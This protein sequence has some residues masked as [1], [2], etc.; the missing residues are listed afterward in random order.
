MHGELVFVFSVQDEQ[1][2]FPFFDER[3]ILGDPPPH[4]HD[5][6][7]PQGK[8]LIFDDASALGNEVMRL[9]QELRGNCLPGDFGF[10]GRNFCNRVHI[11]LVDRH[12]FDMGQA[13]CPPRRRERQRRIDQ[14]AVARQVIG[15][16]HDVVRVLDAVRQRTVGGRVRQDEDGIGSRLRHD[17]EV[18]AQAVWPVPGVGMKMPIGD[19]EVGSRRFDSIE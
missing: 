10:D 13:A 17:I 6:L 14:P 8:T 3:L 5:F 2:D 4:D 19:D 9:F 16:R 12:A 1:V 7:D 15:D 18:F 11:A